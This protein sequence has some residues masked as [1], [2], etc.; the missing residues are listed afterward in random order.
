[1]VRKVFG[2]LVAIVLIG[3]FAMQLKDN[4]KGTAHAASD[5]VNFTLDVGEGLWSGAV[6]FVRDLDL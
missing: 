5:I 2:W 3:G 4:P 6:T 1:M